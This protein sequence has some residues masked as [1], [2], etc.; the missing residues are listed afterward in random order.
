M[1]NVNKLSVIL[2][3]ASLLIISGS[4]I[5][6]MTDERETNEAGS[7]RSNS[8]CSAEKID[9]HAS[10]F[11]PYVC[12]IGTEKEDSSSGDATVS[13]GYMSS[14]CLLK[15]ESFSQKR[16]CT[17]S[18][19]M[20]SFRR[21]NDQGILDPGY[22]GMVSQSLEDADYKLYIFQKKKVEQKIALNND[23]PQDSGEGW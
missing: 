2:V 18:Q 14:F 7:H 17:I 3:T 22:F 21:A 16:E 23:R 4:S 13:A 15:Q 5:H 9:S 20:A 6:A 12:S 19:A 1:V 8:N 10:R 11:R